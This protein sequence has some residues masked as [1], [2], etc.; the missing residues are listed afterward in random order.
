MTRWVLTGATAGAVLACL[1]GA[2]DVYAEMQMARSDGGGGASAGW[3]EL[4]LYVVF[5]GAAA[6]LM[7]G[8]ITWV[9]VSL[10]R[11]M[12]RPRA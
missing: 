12:K 9:T 2:S 11:R 3:G 1:R 8:L 6:G 5:L 4:L 7:G 10:V